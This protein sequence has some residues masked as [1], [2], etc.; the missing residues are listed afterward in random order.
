[1]IPEGNPTHVIVVVV[2]VVVVVVV[3]FATPQVCLSV[4]SLARLCLRLCLHARLVAS[5]SIRKLRWSVACLALFNLTG[6]TLVPG[7]RLNTCC[8]SGVVLACAV[9]VSAIERCVSYY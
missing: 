6:F 7:P 8:L 1:M 3:V 2:I 5:S 9:V 4:C